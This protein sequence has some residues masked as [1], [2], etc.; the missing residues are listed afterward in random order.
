VLC[1]T[2]D[3]EAWKHFGKMYLEF[4]AELRNVR[5]TLCSYG[6]SPFNNSTSP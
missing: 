4:V 3:G 6:F 5:L 2:S 1:Y